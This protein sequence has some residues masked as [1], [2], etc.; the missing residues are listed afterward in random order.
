MADSRDEQVRLEALARALIHRFNNV[1]MGIQ[2]HV[3]VIKRAGKDNERVLASATQIETTLRRAK[4]MMA[5]VSQLAHPMSL[6]I[7]PFDV[8][9]W[10]ETLRRDVQPLVAAPLQLTFEAPPDLVVSGDRRELTR[11]VVNLVN[12]A[13]ESMP[14]GGTIAVSVRGV[15]AG[16]E[17]SIADSG[18]GIAEEM[19]PRIFEPLFTT[20]RNQSGLGL[21]L[22]QHIVEAHGG[23]MRVESKPG[24]GTTVTITLSR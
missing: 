11:A 4:S 17:I 14:Q 3:E 1:L 16:I 6:V 24:A 23:T 15:P 2:P 9:G 22:V 8:Q 5:E 21:P 7:E 19:L 18:T 13:A 10:F 12:N 20:R